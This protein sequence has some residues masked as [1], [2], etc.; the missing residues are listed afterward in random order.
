[1]TQPARLRVEEDVRQKLLY[2][3]RTAG[4]REE[5]IQWKP[6][7]SVPDT[8]HDLTKRERGQKYATCGSCDIVLFDDDSR[9]WHALRVIFE[10]KA[11]DIDAGR[12]Q[13]M[14]YMSN[15]PMAKMGYW[16]N[17]SRN[18]AVY[19]TVDG[20]WIEV[21]N[22]QLPR[23]GDDLTQPPSAPLTWNTMD[24]PLEAALTGAFKRLLDVVVVSDTRSTRREAQLRELVHVLLVKL[25]S[26]FEGVTYPDRPVYFAVQG[27][28][29]NRISRTAEYIRDRFKDLYA[30]RRDTIF[31]RD[32]RDDI[33]LDDA[34]IYQAVVELARFR[35]LF[36]DVEVVSQAFQ[37]FR[38]K[39]LKSGEGQFLT[40]QRVIRPCVMAMD[41]QPEDKVIDPACGTGGFLMEAMRQVGELYHKNNPKHPDRAGMLLTKWANERLYGVDVDD[42][43][44]K[45]TRML[46]LAAG[47]GS[48]HVL[49]GDS[50]ASHRWR[51]HYPQLLGPL[52]DEQYTVVLTNPPFGQN[53]KVRASASK[54][55]G[56][57]IS[58]AA[59]MGGP[60]NYADLEIGLIFLERAWRLLRVGGRVGI[61]LPET[62]FFSHRYRWLPGWLADRLELRGMLNIPM[63]AFQEFCRAKT[64]FYIF[65]KIGR[66]PQNGTSKSTAEEE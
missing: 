58:N 14:R 37:I 1:V 46:M 12:S 33:Q 34:T 61:V 13:L 64:N 2:T 7:W 28:E 45:L 54:A 25:D 41:I 5:Q 26:D 49:I 20:K 39:A 60:N 8:P 23:P 56:F 36:M 62:Y 43:G 31:S 66:G 9:E 59:A 57:T 4:W 35:L 27:D 55:A 51:E 50:I 18:L 3:L 21:E 30:R 48:T 29:N 40:K 10:L 15:E 65:E 53:L 24:D 47:D 42:I 44:V 52:G 63:E 19:K 11:P 38:S 16:S 6:E 17:G 32:D 22:A